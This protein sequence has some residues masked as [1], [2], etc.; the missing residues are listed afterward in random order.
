MAPYVSAVKGESNDK[1]TFYCK[2]ATQMESKEIV[3][4]STSAGRGEGR[5]WSRET[6]NYGHNRVPTP[7]GRR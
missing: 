6:N 5:Q 1:S 7:S 4:A 3:I 2:T